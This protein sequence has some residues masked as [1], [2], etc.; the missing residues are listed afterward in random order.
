MKRSNAAADW[1]AVRGKFVRSHAD[2]V[3]YV[4]N[5]FEKIVCGGKWIFDETFSNF[6]V[7]QGLDVGLREKTRQNIR[8]GIKLTP[9]QNS[10]VI[11]SINFAI[12]EQFGC[13]TPEPSLCRCS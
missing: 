12:K 5:N 1:V 2:W 6:F 3:L 8:N 13:Q 9:K 10:G 11:N 4:E 7:M